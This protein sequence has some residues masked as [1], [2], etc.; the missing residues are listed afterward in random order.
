MEHMT[1]TD[2][3]AYLV[4]YAQC[5]HWTGTEY[6]HSKP[7]DMDGNQVDSIST[8][9]EDIPVPVIATI[10][11]EALEVLA[12]ITNNGTDTDTLHAYA[13]QRDGQVTIY[14]NVWGYV[15]HD[16]CLT[17][18]H[19]GTGLWDRGISDGDTL[20]QRLDNYNGAELQRDTATNTYY[21]EG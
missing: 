11:S 16:A 19:H 7:I 20:S 1:E 4:G 15:G 3:H 18:Q 9:Y 13:V 14:E 10:Y 8:D 17:A 6:D 2:L 21:Y 5:A 12:T